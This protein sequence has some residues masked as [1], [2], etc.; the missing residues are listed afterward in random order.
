MVVNTRQTENGETIGNYALFS[1]NLVVDGIDGR[2]SNLEIVINNL[3]DVET[4]NLGQ[5]FNSSNVS[6][7]TKSENLN[8]IILNNNS[9]INYPYQKFDSNHIHDISFKKFIF[10]PHNDSTYEIKVRNKIKSLHGE[11]NYFYNKFIGENNNSNNIENNELP[12]T[13]LKKMGM[14][15]IIVLNFIIMFLNIM[16]I[17]IVVVLYKWIIM[18]Q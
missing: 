3:F 15:L 9:F 7:N 12:Y 18:V 11:D 2:D 6:V 17:A 16:K 13:K 10:I 14:V 1:S 8:N 5:L 4:D